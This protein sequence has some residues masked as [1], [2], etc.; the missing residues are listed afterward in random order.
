MLNSDFIAQCLS[1]SSCRYQI[2]YVMEC[3]TVNNGNNKN[4]IIPPRFSVVMNDLTKDPTTAILPIDLAPYRRSKITSSGWS[5]L[6]DFMFVKKKNT[7]ELGW[8]YR[9]TW[10]SGLED[11]NIEPWAECFIQ[12][13]HFVRRRLWI[14]TNVIESDLIR[15]KK[16][17]SSS[18]RANEDGAVLFVGKFPKQEKSLM[19]TTWKERIIVLKH[20]EIEFL[21][22]KTNKKVS[23]ISLIGCEPVGFWGSKDVQFG[24]M[25][26]ENNGTSAVINTVDSNKRSIMEILINY[27]ISL[28]SD[29]LNFGCFDF[30]GPEININFANKIVHSGFLQKQGHKVKNWKL[31]FC[32]LTAFDLKYYDGA[33]LKGFID[34]LGSTLEEDEEG[35]FSIKDKSGKVLM[36]KADSEEKANKWKREIRKCTSGNFIKEEEKKLVAK[37]DEEERIYLLKEDEKRKNGMKKNLSSMVVNPLARAKSPSGGD[38]CSDLTRTKSPVGEKAF[39]N[40]AIVEKNER[41]FESIDDDRLSMK[42]AF[43]QVYGSDDEYDVSLQISESEQ[44]EDSVAPVNESIMINE[45][46]VE[47]AESITST[48]KAVFTSPTLIPTP[49]MADMFFKKSKFLRDDEDEIPEISF[50]QS[51]LPK[52]AA[53]TKSRDSFYREPEIEDSDIAEEEVH[54]NVAALPPPLPEKRQR[55]LK[56]VKP[57]PIKPTIDEASSQSVLKA[58]KPPLIEAITGEATSLRR[59]SVLKAEKPL[60]TNL[61]SQQQ[62][63]NP[64]IRSVQKPEKRVSLAMFS[65]QPNPN[66]LVTAKAIT[67]E[68]EIQSKE[69]ILELIEKNKSLAEMLKSQILA[70]VS[71]PEKRPSMTNTVVDALKQEGKN[72]PIKP[73]RGSSDPATKPER[74][75]SKLFKAILDGDEFSRNCPSPS[76]ITSIPFSNVQ[77]DDID[78]PFVV[79]E[80]IENK[81]RRSL[82]LV[83]QRKSISQKVEIIPQ[84]EEEVVPAP[85]ITARKS[86]NKLFGSVEDPQPDEPD[87]T[88]MQQLGDSQDE[89]TQQG[90]SQ[91]IVESEQIE[92]IVESEQTEPVAESE[93]AEPVVESEQTEPVA[94]SEQAEPVVEPE[95][96][97]PIVESEQ[98]EPVA[99]SEQTEPIVEPEQTEPVV[100][101]EQTEPVVEP[102]QAEPIVEP[103]MLNS[104]NNQPFE[105]EQQTVVRRKSLKQQE[106]HSN[107]ADVDLL[108]QMFELNMSKLEA[109]LSTKLSQLES[110]LLYER[111][112]NDQLKAQVE[113]L[114]G[115]HIS[116]EQF[117]KFA[118]DYQETLKTNASDNLASYLDDFKNDIKNNLEKKVDKL[119]VGLE[120][121]GLGPPVKSPLSSLELGPSVASTRAETRRSIINFVDVWN[122]STI[123]A[124]TLPDENF[125][126]DFDVPILNGNDDDT[127]TGK[128]EANQTPIVDQT[129]HE[130]QSVITAESE[131]PVTS[132]KRVSMTYLAALAKPKPVD[133]KKSVVEIQPSS[134]KRASMAYIADLAKPKSVVP[135]KDEEKTNRARRSS[136]NEVRRSSVNEVRR[137]SVTEVR[138]SSV[139]E[140][141][142]SSVT[143]GRRSSL[144]SPER[145]NAASRSTKVRASQVTSRASL[146]YQQTLTK[147]KEVPK[148]LDEAVRADVKPIIDEFN[149]KSPLPLPLLA[150]RKSDTSFIL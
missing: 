10:H 134:V 86:L 49:I 103:E 140:V 58:E 30:G 26:K 126:N 23:T 131:K 116:Q 28:L 61:I 64:E 45:T 22:T 39:S 15:A 11:L 4:N 54:V 111:E 133:A 109:S 20:K 94:E 19:G 95:Q 71:K 66:D 118:S 97:E 107:M 123:D 31:R 137:S 130:V 76:L 52:F 8:Q 5:N 89:S 122:E 114:V 1:A 102:E 16:L 150:P 135:K 63:I 120:L 98:T 138:R 113:V 92:P 12:G 70:P 18:L 132:V 2:L 17:L 34:V 7:D 43:E 25:I 65:S 100:E 68:A 84:I 142:R 13:K 59:Q 29:N 57:L 143:E 24:L 47:A 32:R 96:A 119:I 78:E 38:S 79:S 56:P 53:A 14:T 145:A 69:M 106:A 41:N 91:P 73:D 33:E 88:E 93:Q 6:H 50:S 110:Q 125:E 82:A 67:E 9:S 90:N 83:R 148:S 44:Q 129:S 147:Q 37:E 51:S 87:C 144:T 46:S 3:V 108:K 124:A 85:P 72:L 127:I 48:Q 74:K 115:N 80:N 149:A 121:K 75:G 141:R 42:E 21:D 35:I 27:Q 104:A 112:A 55:V 101:P 81:L 36:M 60:P 99:E 77:A 117:N 105:T 62:V 146:V 136:V 139:A 40:E 128:N